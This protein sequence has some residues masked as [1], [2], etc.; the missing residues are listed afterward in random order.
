[1]TTLSPLSPEHF[2]LVA[3]WLSNPAI[4]RWLSGEWRRN[5]TSAAIIGIAVRNKKNRLFLVSHL[6]VPCGI[7]GLSDIEPLDRTA[8]LWYLLGDSQLAGKGIISDA[9]SSLLGIAFGELDLRSIYAWAMETN[10]ASIRV[11]AKTGFAPAG[12]IRSSANLDG[13]Q[14]DRLYFDIISYTPIP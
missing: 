9:V 11:L 6:G 7:V 3:R 4:H 13:A 14:I 12:R 2:E 8:M 10:A 5:E 1:M